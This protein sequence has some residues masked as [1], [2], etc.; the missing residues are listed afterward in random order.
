VSSRCISADDELLA[1]IDMVL[2][3]KPNSL[4]WLVN[5]VN[6]LR[7]DA[8]QTMRVDKTEHLR[9]CLIRY[10]RQCDMVAGLMIECKIA[11]R[12]ESGS[13]V[14]SWLL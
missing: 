14:R 5:A 7:D 10:F 13:I 11:R 8:F 3:P 9:P 1:E 6:P 2:R 12:S 4:T